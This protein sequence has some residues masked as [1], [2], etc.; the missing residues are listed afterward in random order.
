M[1]VGAA[2]LVSLLTCHRALAQIPLT[3]I[4]ADAGGARRT[5]VEGYQAFGR[6]DYPAT[7]AA[8]RQAGALSDGGD[9]ALYYLGAAQAASGAASDA[10]D[11]YRHLGES[12]PASVFADA[13]GVAY[14]GLELKLGN[15]MAARAAAQRVALITADPQ[16]EQQARLIAAQA[17]FAMN[18]FDI[19]YNEAQALRERYPHGDTDEPAW[20]LAETIRRAHPNVV[21]VAPLEF[22]CRAAQLLVREGR[23][24]QAQDEIASALAESPAAGLRAELLWLRAEASR[25]NEA[26]E[27]T[28][29]LKYLAFA[30]AGLHAPTALNKLAHLYWRTNDT[31]EARHYLDR[32]LTRFPKDASAPEAMLASARTCE[33]D[34]DRAA[35]RRRYRRLIARYPASDAADLARFRAPF[36]LYMD[37]DYRGAAAEFAAASRRAK[38]ED[39]A[40]YAYWD[41]RALEHE[42]QREAG[43]LELREVAADLR[44]NYYPAL[45]LRQLGLET[46]SVVVP[47]PGASSAIP[48]PSAEG[49]NGFHLRRIA[50]WRDL[51]LRELEARELRAIVRGDPALRRFMLDEAEAA[52]AWYDAI[53]MANAMMARGETAAAATERTRYPRG[54][55]DLISG[56]AAGG[57]LDP[58]LVAA[59]IRQESLYNPQARSVSDARGLMQLLPSTAVHWAPAAGLSPGGLDLFDPPTSVRIGTTYLKGLF[60]MFSGDPLKAVAAYNGGEHAVAGWIAKYPGDDDQWVE[61]I[62]YKETRD[63]VKKVIGGRREYRILYEPGFTTAI[64]PPPGPSSGSTSARISSTSP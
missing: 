38:G 33:D 60:E 41:A 13:A 20:T 1:L 6:R 49:V 42:G 34:G 53:Q 10:A 24:R 5:F 15:A 61:N 54:Y 26:A 57:R 17:A 9:Y 16:I 32:V 37:G 3:S 36:M 63:Y 18:D 58:W 8:M 25:G 7:I 40:M 44:S 64:S 39:W 23:L 11:S 22:H 50:L 31:R 14:A 12:Y 46:G 55:W 2:L 47:P 30:P 19:A 35:A 56:A 62:E 51:G 48:I 4:G 27:R 45:A 21:T 59:L 52:G 29:L 43:R 28:A